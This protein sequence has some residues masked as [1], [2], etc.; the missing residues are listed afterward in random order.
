MLQ[1]FPATQVYLPVSS[2]VTS[3]ITREPLGIVWNLEEGARQKNTEVSV[4]NLNLIL[5]LHH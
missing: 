5:Y 4:S 2:V 3:L 1:L